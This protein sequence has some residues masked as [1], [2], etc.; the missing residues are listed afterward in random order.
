M[1]RR[2]STPTRII[3][4]DLTGRRFGRELVV[5]FAESRKSISGRRVKYWLCRCDCG[6]TTLISGT[7]L[8]G[9]LVASCG[10]A[11]TEMLIERNTT[12]GLSRWHPL[13]GTWS[14]MRT[15]CTNNRR[16][17]WENYGGRNILVDPAWEDFA[18]FVA[19]MFPSWS[20]GMTLE[21]IDNNGPY[22][23]ENCR[24]ATRMEQTRNKRNNNVITVGE[25]SKIV[26]DWA[27]YLGIKRGTLYA[28]LNQYGWDAHKALFTPVT[29]RNSKVT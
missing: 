25:V 18:Q 22:K 26:A 28:R 21:R 13:Y 5:A 11:V 29:R 1:A 7:N 16:D 27:D 4:Q 19:D 2:S 23:K 24:W 15:R 12:H 9:G 17:G 8:I 20:T 6:S 3:G 14:S 10:C